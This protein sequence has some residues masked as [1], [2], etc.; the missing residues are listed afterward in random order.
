MAAS[1][2]ASPSGSITFAAATCEPTS[3]LTS[4]VAVE[5]TDDEPMI[6]E[7]KKIVPG[8]RYVIDWSD[9]AS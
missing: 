5:R 8:S 9:T 6:F 1:A 7:P 2:S 3:S 4:S